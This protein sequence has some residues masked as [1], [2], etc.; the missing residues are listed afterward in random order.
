VVVSLNHSFRDD[1]PR[2]FEKNEFVRLL[3]NYTSSHWSKR[4]LKK[5]IHNTA[6]SSKPFNIGECSVRGGYRGGWD[7][8]PPLNLEFFVPIFRIASQS[9]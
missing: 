7:I 8:R 5:K 4:I 6:L 3:N 1:N 9:Q 2:G